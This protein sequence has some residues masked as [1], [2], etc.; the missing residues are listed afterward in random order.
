MKKLGTRVRLPLIGL[1]QRF[2]EKNL[3]KGRLFDGFFLKKSEELLQKNSMSQ[4]QKKASTSFYL[5]SS[6]RRR[7]IVGEATRESIFPTKQGALCRAL[8]KNKGVVFLE[9]RELK[10]KLAE[11]EP[12]QMGPYS[13]VWVGLLFYSNVAHDQGCSTPSLD[14]IECN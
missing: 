11:E 4:V 8:S 10:L 9:E 12:Y 7:Y 2:F 13:L 6:L 1:L 3:P 14:T 5:M